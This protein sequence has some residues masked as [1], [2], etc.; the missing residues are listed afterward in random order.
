M[1]RIKRIF[2]AIKE[3]LIV[4]IL[5]E[6]LVDSE[7]SLSSIAVAY[8]L[9]LSL[10]PLLMTIGNLLPYLN[11]NHHEVLTYLTYF[12][13]QNIYETFKGIIEDLLTN[14]ST[15]LLSV[16]ALA[17]MWAAT[18]GIA[19]L[20]SAMNKAYGIERN[21]SFLV[22]RIIGM[23]VLLLL[24]VLAF[25]G[26]ILQNFGEMIFDFLGFP[27]FFTENVNFISMV[28]TV[29]II[30]VVSFLLYS[31]VPDVHLVKL[32]YFLPGAAFSTFASLFLSQVFGL[33][34]R[35]SAGRM[36]SYQVIGSVI[37]LML[38]LVLTA[39]ILILGSVINSSYQEIKTGEKAHPRRKVGRY[40]V[41]KLLH[42]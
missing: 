8:Y 25:I 36:S 22:S 7:M 10:F 26:A 40:Y 13:P 42:K 34:A 38:W 23:I 18:Q 2:Q 20:Q 30:F 11:I 5:T 17:T 27:T 15:G 28:T 41:K 39:R 6:R 32:R 9:L 24:F 37:V 1:Q 3:N 12:V 14:R 33:Y 35:I 29:I 4:K 31:V 16:S 19:A 21:G